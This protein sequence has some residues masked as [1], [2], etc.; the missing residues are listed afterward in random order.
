MAVLFKTRIFNIFRF[1]CQLNNSIVL[2]KK[3][4]NSTFT[5]SL[6]AKKSIYFS[7]DILLSIFLASHFW[8]VIDYGMIKQKLFW[9][10]SILL[11]ITVL[12]FHYY[13]THSIKLSPVYKTSSMEKLHLK[14]REGNTVKWELSAE[15]ALFPTGKKQVIFDSVAININSTP[16]IHL[17][18]RKGIYEVDKKVVILEDS[19]EVN[20]EKSRITTASLKLQTS[21]D[22]LLTTKDPVQYTGENFII[23]GIGLTAK[24]KQEKVTILDNVKAI[25][26]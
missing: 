8:A 9:V 24:I 6:L 4:N 3:I 21:D 15:N 26:F 20:M 2:I 10:I 14:S 19:V 5:S 16:V 7:P 18:S 12:A 22:L 17:K 1:T 13:S 23:E 11:T 25:Y